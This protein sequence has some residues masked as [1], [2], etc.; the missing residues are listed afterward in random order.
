MKRKSLV[1]AAV[2]AA[3]LVALTACAAPGSAGG[4]GSDGGGGDGPYGLEIATDTDFAAGTT[5]AR[6]ADAGTLTIG[7]KFDQPLFGLL[8]PGNKPEGFDVAIGALVASKL[9]IPFDKIDFIETPS[10]IRETAIQ[11]GDADIVVATYTIN[12][13]RKAVIDFAGPYFEAGQAI[14]V[15]ADND[16]IKGPEDVSGVPV[17][18]VEGST[19]AA[20][21]VDEYNA[22]LFATDVYS[23]CLDPLRNGQVQA[24]TTDNVILS[25]FVDQNPSEFKLVGDGKTFTKEPYG[26]GV[27]KGDDEFRG[28]VNDLLEEAFA[29]GT[30]AKLFEQTAGTVLPVPEP[31]TVDRY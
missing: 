8:G 20:T 18:S 7:T 3:L 21:I 27:K 22:E 6:L 25:G 10:N 5:M 4:N 14:M 2:G 29:D 23:N 13:K 9:G 1:A 28:F 24:V 19:P 15:L 11:N 12:D 16:E 26:I 30:W 31:P 17:C